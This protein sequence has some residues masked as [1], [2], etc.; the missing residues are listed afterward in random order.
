MAIENGRQVKVVMPGHLYTSLQDEAKET[1]VPAASL[2]RLAVQQ[3]YERQRAQY[4][5]V[6]NP[7]GSGVGKIVMEYLV[8]QIT[9]DE[10]V[11]DLTILAERAECAETAGSP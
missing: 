6:A 7:G 3:R 9:I 1:A 2:V 10:L 5:Q 11:D 4:S 8:G